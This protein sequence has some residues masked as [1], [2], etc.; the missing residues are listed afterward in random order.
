MAALILPSD[1]HDRKSKKLARMRHA[2]PPGCT[3]APS[4]PNPL[5]PHLRQQR[6]LQQ[7]LQLVVKM[8]VAPELW[9]AGCPWMPA[10]V[11]NNFLA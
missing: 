8:D 7:L 9:Q 2:Q 10:D 1:L 4:S 3:S 6:H 5:I 11:P